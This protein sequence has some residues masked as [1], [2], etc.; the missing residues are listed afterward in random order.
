MLGQRQS[1]IKPANSAKV[2]DVGEQMRNERNQP[3]F[4][5]LPVNGIMMDKCPN[6]PFGVVT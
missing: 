3:K 1:V 2:R 4:W 6:R 5:T